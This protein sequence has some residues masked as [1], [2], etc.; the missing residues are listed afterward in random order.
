MRNVVMPPTVQEVLRA[1][2]ANRGFL[3]QFKEGAQLWGIGSDARNV[4]IFLQPKISSGRLFDRRARIGP[5]PVRW[6]RVAGRY[7]HL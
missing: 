7:R 1:I 2:L 6:V 5:S 3:V 4:G